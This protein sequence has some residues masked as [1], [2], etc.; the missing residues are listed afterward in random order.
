MTELLM[1]RPRK[2]RCRLLDE[3]GNRC[4][5]EAL[6]DHGLCLADLR[7]AAAEWRRIIDTATAAFPR[8]GDILDA[9]AH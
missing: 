8:L 1:S 5:N 4:A 9:D 2:R 6:N 7:A 3:H